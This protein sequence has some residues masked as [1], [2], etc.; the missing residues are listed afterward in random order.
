MQRKGR[1]QRGERRRE[2]KGEEERP[3]RCASP[4]KKN[5]VMR[6]RVEREPLSLLFFFLSLIFSF[7][8]KIIYS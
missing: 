6:K 8:K 1:I 4:R 2:G 7:Y 3:Q 5:F